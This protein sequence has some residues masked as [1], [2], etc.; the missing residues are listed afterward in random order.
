VLLAVQAL[1]APDILLNRADAPQSLHFLLAEPVTVTTVAALEAGNLQ[2]LCSFIL[3][4]FL[5]C[6]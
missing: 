3:A 4:S 2:E 1:L 5:W 6:D